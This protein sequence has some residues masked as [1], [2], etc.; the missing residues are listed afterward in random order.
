M[1]LKS[2]KNQLTSLLVRAAN[3]NAKCCCDIR[4]PPP[5]IFLIAG[6]DVA[7]VG[8]VKSSINDEHECK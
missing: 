5:Q 8:Q 6:V 1:R 4:K 3:V 7:S 2:S